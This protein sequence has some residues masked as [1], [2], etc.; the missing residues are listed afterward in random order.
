ME[1]TEFDTYDPDT[2]VQTDTDN[3][4]TEHVS[5]SYCLC[6][7]FVCVF[8]PFF[9]ACLVCW[10]SIKISRATDGEVRTPLNESDGA[11]GRWISVVAV[12]FV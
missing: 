2:R 3:H 8:V 4:R 9:L 6:S 12:L 5:Y 11:P 7:S 10:L 1:L